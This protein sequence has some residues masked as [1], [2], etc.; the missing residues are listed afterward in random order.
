ME[1]E[2]VPTIDTP[3]HSTNGGTAVHSHGSGTTALSSVQYFSKHDTIKLTETNFLLWKHQLLFILEGYGLEGFVL[4]TVPT[5]PPFISGDDAQ[6]VENPA[7]LVHKK[8]DKFL[9]S[10]LLST[11]TD[12]ILVH[13]TTAKTSLDIWTTI[14]RRFGAKSSVKISSMRHNLYSIKKS[15]LSIEDYL[16]KVK[17]LSD[18]LTAAGSL[19]TEQEQVSII[20]AGLPIEF[21]SIRVLATA[22]PMTL[23]LV[24]EMLLDCEARQLA[25]LTDIPLQVNLVS[26]Q[27]NQD[28]VK[29]GFGTNRGS[30]QGSRSTG[31][32][33][34]RGRTRGSGRGF[35]ETFSGLGSNLSPSVNYHHL[36]ENP[37]AH[38][39]A[40]PCCGHFSQS[41]SCSSSVVRPSQ[42]TLPTQHWYPNSGATNHVTPTMTNLTDV[43]PYTGTGQ[44][45]MGNGESVSIDNVGS[46]NILAG[47]RLL[48]L[49]DVLHV[50]TVCKNLISVGQFAKDNN[51]YFEFHPVLCFVKDIQTRK[52]LLV[53]RI[54][55]GFRLGHPCSNVLTRVLRSCNVPCKNNALPL[56]CTP[57][58][59]GKSHKLPTSSKTVYSNPFELV[60]SD[61]WGPSHVLSSGYSYYVS[62]VDIYSRYTW[63]YFIKTKSEVP[64]CFSHFYKMI[65]VQFGQSIKMLQTDGGGEFRALSAKLARLGV[66]HR[67]TCPYTS[68]QNG[69]VERRHR[70]IVE[71]GLTLLAK[72]SMPLEYWSDTFSHAVHLINRLPTLVLQ[73]FSP[74]EKLYKVQPDYAQLRVFGS[75]CFP[76]LRPFQPH[77]LQFRSS[78]CVFLGFGSHQKG[79][80]CLAADGRVY[81]SRHVL[82]DELEFP[83]RTGFS[84]FKGDGP[85]QFRHHHSSVPVVTVTSSD[86]GLSCSRQVVSGPSPGSSASPSVLRSPSMV[87]SPGADCAEVPMPPSHAQSPSSDVPSAVHERSSSP[88]NCHPMQTRSNSGIFKPRVFSS[89]LDEKEPSTIDEAFQSAA[90]TTAAKAEYGVL[91]SNHT[92]DLVPLPAGRRAVGCK[93]IF[94][95]KRNA[96]GSVARYKGRLVVKGY[97]QEAGV[98]FYETFSP[99]V[100]PTTVRV[101]LALAV[102]RGWSLRQ[103]DVNNAFLNGD[104]HEDIYMTQPPGFEQHN[105]GGEPLVC[106]LRK[107]LYGLKQAPRAWFHKL[108]DF[109]LNTRFVAS[110]ADSSLFIRQTGTQFLYVL[111]YVDDIIVTRT[112]SSDIKGFIKT[113]HDT[114]S[115][116]DLGQLS[117]FLGI[118]V[119]RTSRGVFLSQKKYILD[120]IQRASMA[121]SKP[122]PIPMVTSC[123]LSAHEG[124]PIED[125]RLFRSVVGALQ[126]V[127]I[128]RPDI[129]FSVNKAC[130]FMHRLL[131]THYK[132]VKRILRYLQGTLD[133][134]L[135]FTRTSKLLLEGYSD[136]SWASDVDDRRSTSGF[137][138]FLGGNPI[139]WSSRKQSVVSR[140]TAEAE[141]RSL[142]QVTAEMVWVQSLLSELGIE[143]THKALLWCDSSAA[144]AVANNPVMHSKFKHVELD[145]CFVRERVANG[146]FQVGH[147]SGQDQAADILTKPLSIGLFDKFRRKLRVLSKEDGNL[148]GR[149]S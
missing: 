2:D 93:W 97:L 65:Q 26:Q 55:D 128:T 148:P 71:M 133:F 58:K 99:V 79:Y 86:S 73:N 17:S 75:A 8:Q 149:R 106:R 88:A 68:E 36:D 37:S 116:K 115:L 52:T 32:G 141:Y 137:C 138:V 74:Y 6:L 63:L 94:K 19:V 62:F 10:W 129:A 91:I 130:Q 142:A 40:S 108:K 124:T 107:A 92:W 64:R 136:A 56:R 44:V 28:S 42:T 139:S 135:C 89:V 57:C 48:R 1:T 38:C 43:S 20:L 18:S 45:S 16:S 14:N 15:N 9:A 111:V 5:P 119:T 123:K 61:V 11:V 60:T 13:L 53:G 110:K 22:T 80:R 29:G 100:K 143:V 145:L 50:P 85:V 114:F 77:K 49:R 132:A 113:L 126:Y 104:L 82:F 134:G 98:D 147:I 140:S 66:Q 76:H 112:D 78:K 125:E 70:H 87:S 120:L 81:V 21:E 4:G 72:A 31:R 23:E 27:G 59:I 25:M 33:W 41:S 51:V 127:V 131:D 84:C 109:L 3:R 101:M 105:G 95:V 34:S 7:F 12:D 39:S 117:Y 54:H 96:D 121:K 83:F 46:S 35:D 146:S 30:H 103:V 24:T 122:S 69:V 144:V 90:W 102:S 47:S 67:V 118:E